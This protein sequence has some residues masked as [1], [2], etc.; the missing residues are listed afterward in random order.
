MY[1]VGNM[2]NTYYIRSTHSYAPA[3]P[4]L[5]LVVPCY[6]EEEVLPITAPQFARKI[7]AL[8]QAGTISPESGVLF[9]DDGSS[10]RTWQIIADFAAQSPLFRG[11]SLS[12][13]RGHQ[14]ALLAGLD[15]AREFC[16]ISISIDADGQDD[17]DAIDDMVAAYLDGSDVV[18]GVRSDR[19]SDTAGKRMSAESF[20]KL[21]KSLGAET[22]FNHADY[23]LMSKRA[24]D[25]L[26]EFPEVNLY[27]RGLVPL[28]GYPSSTVEYTREKRIAGESH[29]PFRKMLSLAFDGITSLSTK[30]LHIIAGVGIAFSIVG[31]IGI[32]WAIVTAIAGNTVAGWASTICVICLLGGLQLLSLGII[33][34]YIG[35]VYLETKQRPRFI[36]KERTYLK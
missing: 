36:I 25:G 14:N 8:I 32:I 24:M 28:V 23:R 29:Y 17:I 2:Q 18:Y 35:K 26:M 1:N 16:D 9:V 10:D 31:L 11:V 20:Y 13:N 7:D 21:M 15:E 33:G 34:E 22:V 27:L 4:V 12:R 5:W 6:N 3:S 19:T 30:P